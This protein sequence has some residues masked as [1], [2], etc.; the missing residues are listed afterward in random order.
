MVILSK[1]QLQ[2]QQLLRQASE[3]STT[4]SLSET[5]S[6]DQSAAGISQSSTVVEI[7]TAETES[8]NQNQTTVQPISAPLTSGS[9][10][11]VVDITA[12]SIKQEKIDDPVSVSPNR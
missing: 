1:Y 9:T 5:H 7:N 6:D 10:E 4:G 2:H 3:I 12:S 11:D 8:T